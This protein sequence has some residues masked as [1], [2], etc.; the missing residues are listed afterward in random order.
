MMSSD[1]P[2]W[3]P[4]IEVM[5]ETCQ[6]HD[7]Y[8]VQA[9]S[10]F[11]FA[12]FACRLPPDP[13]PKSLYEAYLSLYAAAIEAIPP[14]PS[15][16]LSVTKKAPDP[17]EDTISYNLAMMTNVMAICPR[18]S[19]FASLS[20]GGGEVGFNGTVMAGTFMLKD[21]AVWKRINQEPEKMEGVLEGIGYPFPR[22]NSISIEE[23][24]MAYEKL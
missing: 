9:C 22:T 19:E 21:E 8:T 12:H 2:G 7:D 4:A 1:S 18:R 20:G 13:E 10:A 11:P 16:D 23:Q 6:D 14:P 15:E 17:P 5:S 3:R 24:E